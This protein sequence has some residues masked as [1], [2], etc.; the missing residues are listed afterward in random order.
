MHRDKPIS[1]THE[2]Y[3]KTLYQVRSNH[4]VARVRDLAQGL[5]VSPA[6]VSSVLKKLEKMRLVDHERYGVIAL[7]PAGRKVAECIVERFDT[8]RAVLV[9][10]FG[11]DPK[12]AAVDACMM[13]HAVSPLTVKRMQALLESVRSGRSRIEISNSSDDE[14]AECERLGVCQAETEDRRES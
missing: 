2:M 9:E 4:D 1:E 3:L 11:V 13:E 8:V 12:T 10:V 5:G 7:T 6:T 14:C